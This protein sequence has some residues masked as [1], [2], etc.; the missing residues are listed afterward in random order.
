MRVLALTRYDSTGPS[1]R[2]RFYQFR[3]FL[4]GE[5]L[6]VAV[7]PLL[8]AD[9]V[10]RLLLGKPRSIG[11]LLGCYARRLS[12]IP[13]WRRSDL[14]W[15]EKELFPWAPT[16]LDPGL[17]GSVPYVVDYD[18]AVFHNYDEHR[19]RAIRAMYTT[20]IPRVMR[21]ASVVVAGNPYI[22]EFAARAG[23]R[24]IEIVPSVV[25]GDVY[26]PREVR[27]TAKFTVGWVGSPS[28]QHFLDPLWDTLA[29]VIDPVTDRFVTLGA[30]CPSP[31]FPGHEPTA[32]SLEGEPEALAE[33]DVGIMPLRDAPFERGKCG[34][35]LV[36]YMACGVPMVASPVGVNRSL[37]DH[38]VTGYLVQTINEW[39]AA[40]YKLKSEP[41]LRRSMSA[42]ARD[43]FQRRYSFEVNAPRL[44]GILRAAVSGGSGP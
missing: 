33:F 3:D 40:L 42:A 29:A 38:G 24:H 18:D 26:Y 32:W 31:V 4:A 7:Q 6:E 14:L 22:A 43:V 37:V 44:A 23:A 30:R 8:D 35:K 5:G 41:Q 10:Q 28:T 25:R 20:K 19:L 16:L 34:F 2:V 9:Y 12:K 15:I 36:Q 27:K 1:S 17:L 13:R 39:K 21:N 11:N